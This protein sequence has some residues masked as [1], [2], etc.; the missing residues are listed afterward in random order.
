M[1]NGDD[2]EKK[3]QEWRDQNKS[4]RLYDPDAYNLSDSFEC[5]QSLLKAKFIEPLGADDREQIIYEAFSKI[6]MAENKNM[7]SIELFADLLYAKHRL[8]ASCGDIVKPRRK[9]WWR[10]RP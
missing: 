8:E 3:I 7:N 2:I 1:S 9:P 6:C 4:V 5:V 10:L